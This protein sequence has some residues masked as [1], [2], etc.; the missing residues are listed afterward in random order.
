MREDAWLGKRLGCP[1][2][3]VENAETAGELLASSPGFFQ[4]RVPTHDVARVGLLE[5]I[6]FRTIDVTVTLRRDSGLP[7]PARLLDVRDARPDDRDAVIAI[8]ERDY[9]VS[10]FHLDPEIP[11]AVARTIK[12]DWTNNFFTGGRGDRMLVVEDGGEL[13]GFELVLDTPEA[14]VIDLIAVAAGARGRGVGSALVCALAESAPDRA[15]QAGTQI[16]NLPALRLYER[17]GFA[18][19]RTDY[20]L[21]RHS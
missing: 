7:L 4:A 19:A 8:A 6:G 1:A 15:V 16:A 20:V 3:T 9:N 17:L 12:R 21:H 18:V 10:R 11:D 13:A 2:W 5:G 14:A